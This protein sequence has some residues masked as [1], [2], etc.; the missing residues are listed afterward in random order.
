MKRIYL[1]LVTLFLINSIRAQSPVLALGEHRRST[2][3]QDTYLKDLD[4]VL[5]NFE[6]T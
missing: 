5:N 3:A 6:G 2:V 4:N 1:Y